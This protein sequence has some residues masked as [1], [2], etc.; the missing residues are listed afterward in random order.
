M[1]P[2]KV[3]E[4]VLDLVIPY[5]YNVEDQNSVSL[6]SHKFYE[7]DSRLSKRFPFIKSLTLKELHIYGLATNDEDLETLA[8]T[9]GKDLRSLKIRMCKGFLPYGL[10]HVSKL[11]HF[12]GDIWDEESDLVGFQLPPSMRSLSIKGYAVTRYRIVLPFLNQ[13]RKLKFE[14]GDLDEDSQLLLL[15]RCPNLE[16][17]YTEDVC[18]D[19]GLQV[20]G[21]F[22]KKLRKLTHRG[23]VNHVGL[24]A[25]AK[26]CIN[27]ESIDVIIEDISNEALEC[28]GTHLKNLRDFHISDLFTGKEDNM[29]D[30]PIDNGVRAMLMGCRKLERLDIT[31]LHGGLT[32]VGLEYIGKYGANLRSLSL[33]LI[34]NSNAGLVKL[35]EG[36]QSLRKLRL[37]CCP[38]SKQAVTSSVFNI[39][40][41]RYVWFDPDFSVWGKVGDHTG[42]DKDQKHLFGRSWLIKIHKIDHCLFYSE[43]K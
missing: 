33:T 10:M 26:G 4:E 17:L 24:I 6:V 9:H 43:R 39:P 13:I 16:V 38:F 30:L 34:G 40:T 25:L 31:L 22:C 23:R 32:D 12:G 3:E 21:T 18:G 29:T 27:L 37:R 20:I 1:A 42:F 11:E 5:I 35:L 28:V 19:G 14:F 15:K 2:T 41:L 8:R 7:I 36:C